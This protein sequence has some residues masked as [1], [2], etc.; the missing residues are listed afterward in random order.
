MKS[1]VTLL[2]SGEPKHSDISFSKL[3]DFTGVSYQFVYLED[4]ITRMSSLVDNVKGSG[5]CL[6]LNGGTLAAIHHDKGIA[7][8]FKSLLKTMEIL[9]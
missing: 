1:V 3:V 6:A 4:Y 7:D 9:T 5:A 8:S 2:C